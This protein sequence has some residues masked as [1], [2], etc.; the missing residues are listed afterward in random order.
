MIAGT[1]RY[2]SP[3]QAIAESIDRRSDIYIWSVVLYELL[4]GK[5]LVTAIEARAI[6]GAVVVDVPPPLTS[7]N[8]NLSRSL[9]GVLAKA[10]EKDPEK[11]F[12]TALELRDALALAA[13]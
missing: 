5:Q 8:P 2:M 3:E 6:L 9:D 7:R 10:L 11:R 1:L 13:G 4:T 12:K